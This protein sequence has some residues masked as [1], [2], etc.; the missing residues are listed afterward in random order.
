MTI[1]EK[2]EQFR[3]SV[4]PGQ[5]NSTEFLIQQAE[6]L[7]G[8][9]VELSTRILRRVQNL[10]KQDLTATV[11]K[12]NQQT[13]IPQKEANHSQQNEQV[14]SKIAAVEQE[15][16]QVLNENNSET[17]KDGVA[18][19]SDNS[20]NYSSVVVN[21]QEENLD[22]QETSSFEAKHSF[23]LSFFNQNPFSI[24]VIVPVIIFSLYQIL[25]ATPRYESRTQ[26]IVQQPDGMATM[27]AGMALLSGLGVNT[28]NSDTQLVKAYIYSNDM[29]EYLDKELSLR[30]HFESSEVDFFSRMHGWH[31]RE[32]FMDY[33]ASRVT[34]EIDEKSQIISVYAQ[35]FTPEFATQLAE[36]IENKAE[37]YIN[38]IG[39][40]L[41]EAQLKFIKGEHTVVERRLQ[42]AQADLLKFQQQHNLLSPET[43]GAALS[44]IAYRL[45]GEIATKKAELTAL[46]SI[47]SN[48]AP[49]VKGLNNQ[50]Y[51][52]QKQ[53]K[54]E[55]KRLTSNTSKSGSEQLN[56]LPISEVLS[57]FADL[58][59]DLE[60]A[61]KGFT[62]STISLE[63]SR[64]EAYRQLKYL[65][66]VEQA[67]I[68][69]DDTYP[70]VMY[71]I[72]LL[73]V[74]LML[75]YGVGRIIITTVKELK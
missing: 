50:I 46:L 52:L 42:K 45:E 53:L 19:N 68:P 58:K 75:V 32:D 22:S 9:D 74:L 2:F 40:Q 31:S 20:V 35:S 4:K 69:E 47:M 59:I 27:D 61:V 43:E 73:S 30:Q 56:N 29:L 38:D 16:G 72:S 48:S 10:N 7:K 37:W 23:N 3:K 1:E 24:F 60:L 71:N 64:I 55:K 39:H 18:I 67:T 25:W 36:T 15:Q 5:F 63:K 66:L 41:A 14:E 17:K 70:A 49:Q 28:T 51:A 65:V 44:E 6:V 33:F 13:K 34:V 12:I 8:V 26:V 62:S 21:K 57:K 11:K 54:S